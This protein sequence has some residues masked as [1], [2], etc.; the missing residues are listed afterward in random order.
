MNYF[1]QKLRLYN[2]SHMNSTEW[3]YMLTALQITSRTLYLLLTR[4][5]FPVGRWPSRLDAMPCTLQFICDTSALFWDHVFSFNTVKFH[6]QQ[7]S[8]CS[9]SQE[10]SFFVITTLLSSTLT[11]HLDNHAFHRETCSHEYITWLHRG[12][13]GQSSLLFTPREREREREGERNREK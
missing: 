5:N 12:L 11:C 7:L 13:Q 4:P 9:L 2:T 3:R 10:I 1:R 8:Q 6:F